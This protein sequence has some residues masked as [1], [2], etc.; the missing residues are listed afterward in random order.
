MKNKKKK[1]FSKRI[2]LHLGIAV[3]IQL[4]IANILMFITQDLSP[5]MY[6]IPLM[7]AVLGLGLGFYFKK[8]EAENKIKLMKENNIELTQETFKE[9][10]FKQGDEI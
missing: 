6:I 3:E 9:E 2:I 1:E 8:A 7:Q 10:I 5:L 4:V